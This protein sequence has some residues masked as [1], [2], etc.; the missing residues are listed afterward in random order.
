MLVSPTAS[1]K[2]LIIYS[3]IR[4]YYHLLKGEQIFIL[5]TTSLVEQMYSDFIDYGWDDKYLHRI[6]QGIMKRIQINL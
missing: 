6:Y 5:V 2:S 3:L 4:F 1:G